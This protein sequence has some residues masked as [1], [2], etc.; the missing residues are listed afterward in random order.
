[1]LRIPR[2]NSSENGRSFRTEFDHILAALLVSVGTSN[3]NNTQTM[4]ISKRLMS[5]LC[6][7]IE[8]ARLQ[9]Q[10]RSF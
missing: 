6:F 4:M 1:M 7:G 10:A 2:G 9:P 5:R 3:L 8:A